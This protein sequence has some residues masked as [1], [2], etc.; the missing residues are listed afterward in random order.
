MS[1]HEYRLRAMIEDKQQTWDLSDNDVASIKWALSEIDG[2]RLQTNLTQGKTNGEAA[3]NK[4][5]RDLY[6]KTGTELEVI[7]RTL[8]QFSAW[9]QSGRNP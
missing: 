2:Y 3:E 5:L 9:M 6:E 4:R 7:A 1:E 8:A